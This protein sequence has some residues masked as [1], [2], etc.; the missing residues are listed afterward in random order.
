[1]VDLE[2]QKDTPER[3]RNKL[4]YF[5]EEELFCKTENSS[6]KTKIIRGIFDVH[7]T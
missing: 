1:V 2:I 6:R 4:N 5:Y 3:K 7:H